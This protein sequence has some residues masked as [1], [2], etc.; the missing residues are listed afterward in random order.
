[1]RRKNRPLLLLKVLLH[2]LAAGLLVWALWKGDWS[3]V[4]LCALSVALFSLPALLGRL[5]HADIP[6]VL[7]GIAVCFAAAANLGGEVLG[8]Y[9]LLPFWDS[10][11]HLLWGLLAAVIGYAM[12][13]LLGRREGISRSLPRTASVLLAVSF[14]MLTAVLWEFVEYGVDFF[15]HTDMQKD[16]W[17]RVIHSVLLQPEGA[18]TQEVCSVTVNGE[19]WPALL[20]IGL[21]DTVHDM[22]WT[23]LGSLP[24]AALTLTDSGRGAPSPLLSAL[25]PRPKSEKH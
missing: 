17:V 11:L 1:M 13:D 18:V 14:C 25:L 3:H 24:G 5:F 4:G 23:F 21:R 16:S 15:F 7:E 10:A 6:P 9:V 2:L 8:L 20:D 12:P 22:L 19:E